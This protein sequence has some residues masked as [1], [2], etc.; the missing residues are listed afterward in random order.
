MPSRGSHLSL[1]LAQLVRKRQRQGHQCAEFAAKGF[2]MKLLKRV[3][4]SSHADLVARDAMSGS[5]HVNSKKHDRNRSCAAAVRARIDDLLSQVFSTGWQKGFSR[6]ILANS[7]RRSRCLLK[8]L[9]GCCVW[10]EQIQ[11]SRAAGLSADIP[12]SCLP[13]P[14]PPRGRMSEYVATLEGGS[15]KLKVSHGREITWL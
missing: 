1:A 7:P 12:L 8:V 5:S 6:P 9:L 2:H 11:S 3:P 4:R 13:T 15:E 10:H 14:T